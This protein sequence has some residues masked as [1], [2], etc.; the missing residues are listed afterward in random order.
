[1][2]GRSSSLA[3]FETLVRSIHTTIRDPIEWFVLKLTLLCITSDEHVKILDVVKSFDRQVETLGRM[4]VAYEDGV[5]DGQHLRTVI[6]G[7]VDGMRR[8][9]AAVC[10]STWKENWKAQ[11]STIEAERKPLSP[12][13]AIPRS[14]FPER[15]AISE[16]NA[17]GAKVLSKMAGRLA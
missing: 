17:A 11:Y 10:P 14:E 15:V 4:I 8:V 6:T 16:K 5:G 2:S 1:M 13:D 9:C 3:T 7:L 12:F